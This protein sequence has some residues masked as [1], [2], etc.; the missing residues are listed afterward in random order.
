MR[1]TYAKQRN[2]GVV[3]HCIISSVRRLGN[4]SWENLHIH[5]RC[6]KK[7]AFT[8]Q[9]KFHAILHAYPSTQSPMIPYVSRQHT[10]HKSPCKLSNRHKRCHLTADRE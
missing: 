3:T 5:T 10:S 7:L 1:G 8:Y 2:I 6:V 9:Q 4:C